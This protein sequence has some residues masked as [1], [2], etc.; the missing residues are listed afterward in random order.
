MYVHSK[1]TNKTK[2]TRQQQV[3]PPDIIEQ[4]LEADV[5]GQRLKFRCPAV[6]LKGETVR[7]FFM[8]I[9][10]VVALSK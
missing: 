6:R 1:C 8:I 3:N 7:L 10:R 9:A 5:L 4:T 2:T